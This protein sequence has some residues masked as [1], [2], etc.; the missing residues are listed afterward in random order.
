[1]K[2]NG[3]LKCILIL[4][5]SCVF[6]ATFLKSKNAPAIITIKS[7]KE[8]I[9]RLENN[10]FYDILSYYLPENPD[11]KNYSKPQNT[12][13]LTKSISKI[14]VNKKILKSNK[15]NFNSTS[16]S[17]KPISKTFMRKNYTQKLDQSDNLTTKAEIK[18][19]TILIRN[20]FYNI[21][22][23]IFNYSETSVSCD[24][25]EM[26]EDLVFNC[27]NTK[28][29]ELKNKLNNSEYKNTEKVIKII[30]QKSFT[31]EMRKDIFKYSS[32]IKDT[33]LL[34][35]EFGL[36]FINRNQ[37]RINL[38]NG[39]LYKNKNNDF[40]N[41]ESSS[42]PEPIFSFSPMGKEMDFKVLIKEINKSQRLL[43]NS[44]AYEK[45]DI[46]LNQLDDIELNEK[47]DLAIE[48]AKI[49]FEKLNKNADNDL[50]N[51]HERLYLCAKN[52]KN[53]A[54]HFFIDTTSRDPQ[55]E[56]IVIEN[57]QIKK[58]FMFE[59]KA[60]KTSVRVVFVNKTSDCFEEF[61]YE[62]FEFSNQNNFVK[63]DFDKKL[64]K[65]FEG[66]SSLKNLFIAIQ[67]YALSFSEFTKEN[68][69][70]FFAEGFLNYLLN[71][72]HNRI[73]LRAGN[74]NKLVLEDFGE[75]SKNESDEVYLDKLKAR[76]SN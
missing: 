49:I 2:F 64:N 46:K 35:L 65:I 66:K 45:A 57:K 20:E 40:N 11:P 29:E 60:L 23:Q 12:K 21:C 32:C 17:K 6:I 55:K 26:I 58:D 63:N 25:A 69:S 62:N 19:N 22:L 41:Q 48:N 43:K 37:M 72:K 10:T 38:Q 18:K 27:N 50:N 15:S 73:H 56:K 28:F 16:N 34:E 9:K 5:N 54:Y 75:Y 59:D 39:F 4:I 36:N 14:A 71:E 61:N 74:V 13:T 53:S 67:R 1:M 51:I 24:K 3:I 76:K 42:K 8:P 52:N 44:L 30:N 7:S 47:D 31:M 68:N 70:Q 33:P